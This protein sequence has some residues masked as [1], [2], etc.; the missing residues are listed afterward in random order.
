MAV[1][2]GLTP[3]A[4]V[5]LDTDGGPGTIPRQSESCPHIIH[6][7]RDVGRIADL[8]GRLSKFSRRDQLVREDLMF[9]WRDEYAGKVAI[10]RADRSLET[11]ELVVFV[12]DDVAAVVVDDVQ[13]VSVGQSA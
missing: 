2:D 4:N 9:E 6:D 11:L 8:A 7:E 3:A 12:G 5:R 10:R 1:G 13:R